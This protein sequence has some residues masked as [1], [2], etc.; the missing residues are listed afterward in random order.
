ML[1]IDIG[2]R[3]ATHFTLLL[4]IEKIHINRYYYFLLLLLGC[5][6]YLHEQDHLPFFKIFPYTIVSDDNEVFIKFEVNAS[7]PLKVNEVSITPAKNKIISLSMGKLE[8]DKTL[9]LQISDA[10][11]RE[12]I[13]SR[14]LPR[15]PC[16][17]SSPI[18]LGF[19]SDTHSYFTDQHKLRKMLDKNWEYGNT[20][21]LLHGGDIVHKGGQIEEWEE[22]FA[23][24]SP[25]LSYRPIV[26]TIGNHE[27]QGL[28]FVPGPPRV[29][30]QF[31]K[32]LRGKT[33]P[34]SSFVISLPQC[35]I[36]IFNSNLNRMSSIDKDEQ[37]G[38]IEKEMKR[39]LAYKKAIIVLLHYPVFTSNIFKKN[40]PEMLELKARLVP[41]LEKYKV[42]LVLSGDVHLYERSEKERVNYL[43][44]GAFAWHKMLSL[45]GN[46]YQKF[47]KSFVTTYIWLKVTKQ[48]IHIKTF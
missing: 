18:Y 15:I 45:W 47:S 2:W 36:I 13:F 20:N 17:D 43:T 11:T 27:Y 8:C 46:P 1:I 34:R 38:F 10:R 37:W 26:S 41:L 24:A 40:K 28:G 35:N 9:K 30:W 22:F 39:A 5:T 21:L 42:P 32:Y 25:A 23:S 6:S 16:D 3:D 44:A 7:L 33:L 29:P 48:K 14:E 19:I 31:E 4:K 12:E